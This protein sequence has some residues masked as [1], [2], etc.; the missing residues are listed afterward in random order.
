MQLVIE[1]AK[2]EREKTRTEITKFKTEMRGSLGAQQLKDIED[3]CANLID[4]YEKELS[5]IKIKKYRRDTLDYKNNRVYPWLAGDTYRRRTPQREGASSN[6]LS[7]DGSTNGARYDRSNHRTAFLGEPRLTRSTAREGTCEDGE[8]N[9]DPPDRRT[10][11]QNR[12]V[13]D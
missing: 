7:T 8:R 9:T 10:G 5:E 12:R 1:F 13:K 11:R 4:K 2:E 6:D 3:Q